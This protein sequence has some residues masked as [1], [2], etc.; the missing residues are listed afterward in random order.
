MEK[1]VE[2]IPYDRVKDIDMVRPFFGDQK[3]IM[4]DIETTGLSPLKSFTY[5]I[6]INIFT[7]N[8]WQ[9]IQLFNDD[10]TSEPEMIRTFQEML[11]DYDVLMHF[12][13][14]TFDIPYIQKRMQFIE[15]RFSIS[16]TDNFDTLRSFDLLKYVRPYKF[17]LGLPNLKQKTIERYIGLDRVDMFNGGQLIDVYLGYLASGDAHSRELVL[18]HNR[19]DMEGMIYLTSMLGIE[20]MMKGEFGIADLSTRPVRGGEGIELVIK[21]KLNYPVIH[22]IC[23]LMDGMQLDAERDEFIL[24]LPVYYG[25]MN[26]YYGSS[27]K[28]GCIGAEGY[29]TRGPIDVMEKLPLYKDKPKSRQGYIMLSDNFLGEKSFV[30]EFSRRIISEIMH[31]KRKY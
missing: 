29:F 16:L 13:G 27:S 2:T 3:I 11:K 23:N 8:E 20:L 12:N 5:L 30:K 24:K 31:F 25:Y 6:G 9:I 17:A 15:H 10:G 19:D 18:R 4:F 28:D 21:G 1:I 7:G 22:P 14:D 26:Y